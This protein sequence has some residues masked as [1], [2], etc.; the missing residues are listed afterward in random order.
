MI[1]VTSNEGR[2]EERELEGAVRRPKTGVYLLVNEEPRSPNA[3]A[4]RA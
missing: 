3:D 1:I 4:Y 2:E